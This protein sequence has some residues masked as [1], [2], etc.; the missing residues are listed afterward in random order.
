[1]YRMLKKKNQHW[2]HYLQDKIPSNTY[3]Y[4]RIN[5]IVQKLSHDKSVRWEKPEDVG[6]TED[7]PSKQNNIYIENQEDNPQRMITQGAQP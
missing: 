1:M 4:N 2:K 5:H 7:S 3:K 6:S